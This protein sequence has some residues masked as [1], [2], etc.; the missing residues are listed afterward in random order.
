MSI[1]L[2][3]EPLITVITVAYNSALYIRDTIK[4]VLNQNYNNIEYIIGDDSSSD[5]TWS[6]INEFDDPRIIKY[7]NEINIGEYSNRNKA[8]HL[9]TG[10]YLIFIDG[11]DIMFEHA[12]ATFVYYVKQ[13]PESGMFFSRDWDYRLLP[14][15]KLNPVDIYRFHFF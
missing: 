13:F 5:N 3:S 6:I 14:P 9:A 15:V 11:D 12:L 8:L 1:L 10:E 7:R 4:S 2:N